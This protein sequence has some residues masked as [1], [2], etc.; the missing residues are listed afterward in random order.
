M[1]G[2]VML[3]LI[4]PGWWWPP[5]DATRP[6]SV[7]T[8]DAPAGGVV[9]AVA[10]N[11]VPVIL[12]PRRQAVLSAAVTGR[13]AVIHKEFGE[14]F[15][16]GQPLLQLDDSTYRVNRQTAEAVLEACRNEV[17]RVQKLTDDKTRQRHADAVLAAAHANLLATQHLYD[18]NHAAQIDLE[19]AR[20]DVAVAQ[21]NR[22][23]VDSTVA[24]EVTRARRELAVAQGK[25]DLATEQ[26]QD[27]TLTAPWDGRVKRVLINA[28]EFVQP[29]TSLME[30]IDD[31]VLLAKFLLPSS[32]F[33]S[34][35][36]GQELDLAVTETGTNVRLRVSHLAAVLDPVSTT[37]EV[38][39][40]VD[41]AAGQLRAGM[42]GLLDLTQLRGR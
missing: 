9:T 7:A 25:G 31:R 10:A 34:L 6:P 20:R 4:L 13:V 27:C 12:A 1:R 11:R 37:F 39:A 26:L 36:V 15:D 16:S 40:E 21:A 3:P 24:E 22:E 41:N 5:A 18:G 28:R 30:V 42:N 29:G 32:A 23:L 19:N 14:P 38:H 2:I 17:A 8:T 33:G 35:H